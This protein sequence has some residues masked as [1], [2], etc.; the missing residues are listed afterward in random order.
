MTPTEHAIALV[1]MATAI[2]AILV[3]GTLAA[4]EILPVGRRA[5]VASR[6]ARRRRT[7]GAT[8]LRR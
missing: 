4:A 7:A 6:Q 2:I 8:D 1:V 5:P 3:I